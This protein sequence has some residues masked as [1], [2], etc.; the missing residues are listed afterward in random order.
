[1]PRSE[2]LVSISS[3]SGEVL[4]VGSQNPCLSCILH[5]HFRRGPLH[6]SVNGSFSQQDL[7]ENPCNLCGSRAPRGSTKECGFWRS[8]DPEKK[9]RRMEDS[10]WGGLKSLEIIANAPKWVWGS[11][12][13]QGF[14]DLGLLKSR[15][16]P[17]VKRFQSSWESTLLP[18]KLIGFVAQQKAPFPKLGKGDPN[19]FNLGFLIHGTYQLRL[20]D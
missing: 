16:E 10:P 3:T 12:A 13:G 2:K 14:F 17:L 18:Q 6:P 11:Q 15:L 9:P 19:R 7:V 1:M 4:R 5:H 20:V 8:V